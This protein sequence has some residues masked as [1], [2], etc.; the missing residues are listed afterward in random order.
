MPGGPE[1]GDRFGAAMVDLDSGA[2][3]G[4]PGEDIGTVRDAGAVI[5]LAGP[6]ST[7]LTTSLWYQGH[8]G[9]AG[10]LEPGDRF[11]SALALGLTGLL[12]GA[13]YEDV[14]DVRDA[15]VIHFLPHAHGSGQAFS[16][17]SDRQIHQNTPDIPGAAMA[18]DRF[19]SSVGFAGDR[20]IIGVSGKRVGGQEN[21]GAIVDVAFFRDGRI[22]DPRRARP[23]RRRSDCSPRATPGSAHPSRPLRP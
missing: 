21:A 9:I 18:G 4:A 14:R 22:L 17:E 6:D 23:P 7:I 12:I 16:V 20:A 11:G 13:P 10:T 3:I 1:P 5:D 8:R 15:G 19:G 2:A